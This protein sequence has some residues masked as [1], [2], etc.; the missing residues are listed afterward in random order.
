MILAL[1]PLQIAYTEIICS[2]SFADECKNVCGLLSS[3]ELI[4]LRWKVI[5]FSRNINYY[6]FWESTTASVYEA[7]ETYL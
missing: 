6:T 5:F 7:D 2:N 1:N 4:N 3:S